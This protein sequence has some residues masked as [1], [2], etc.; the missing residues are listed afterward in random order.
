MNL[1][2]WPSTYSTEIPGAFCLTRT[3]SKTCLGCSN[4]KVKQANFIILKSYHSKHKS[5]QVWT[6]YYCLKTLSLLYIIL[7]PPEFLIYF[8]V[9][10]I[11]T[12]NSRF[13]DSCHQWSTHC[14]QCTPKSSILF[15]GIDWYSEG[16]SSGGLKPWKCTAKS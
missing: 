6:K 3:W 14:L 13:Y 16:P 11:F 7:L 8:N 9:L 4:W 2:C 10:M 1:V 12:F 5:S 15:R